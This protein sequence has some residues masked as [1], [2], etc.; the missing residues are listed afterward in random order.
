MVPLGRD[1][2][3]Q[4]ADN[5]D[6]EQTEARLEEALLP[7][8]PRLVHVD[9]GEELGQHLSTRGKTSAR[10]HRLVERTRVRA[11]VEGARP[12]RR[13]QKDPGDTEGGRRQPPQRQEVTGR[14]QSVVATPR[15]GGGARWVLASV[16]RRF[17]RCAVRC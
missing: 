2:Y 5:R 1:C 15:D 11:H 3:G 8:Q 4:G 13:E 14:I 7:W 10:T 12:H 17:E 9:R 16:S 6:D